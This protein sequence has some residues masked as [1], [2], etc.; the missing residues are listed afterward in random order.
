MPSSCVWPLRGPPS[1]H[2]SPRD[3]RPDGHSREGDRADQWFF[4]QLRRVV[5]LAQQDQ[6]ARVEQSVECSL[7]FVHRVASTTA[8]MSPRRFSGSAPS[9]PAS[10]RPGQTRWLGHPRHAAATASSTSTRP[11][12]DPTTGVLAPTP[13]AE[14]PQNV[15]SFALWRPIFVIGTCGRLRTSAASGGTYCP[16]V[17]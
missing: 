2:R 14:V 1:M 4:G 10:S 8:S 5:E 12:H 6:R 13:K 17:V 3:K 7:T 15:E 11:P 16:E 9:P